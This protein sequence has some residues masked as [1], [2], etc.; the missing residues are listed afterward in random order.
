MLLS[1]DS[2]ALR[3]HLPI[4]LQLLATTPPPNERIAS[5]PAASVTDLS[6]ISTSNPIPPPPYRL[7]AGLSL[8]QASIATCAAERQLP[9]LAGLL[10]SQVGGKGAGEG[11]R[12]GGWGRRRR[13]L[14]GKG[15]GRWEESRRQ[16]APH[17]PPSLSF[18]HL[19][20]PTLHRR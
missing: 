11:G 8:L 9:M 12:E 3:P 18:L 10:A 19:P 17:T 1:L 16:V 13:Q 7:D 2:L 4:L 5:A 14:G 15:S 20:F 6:P